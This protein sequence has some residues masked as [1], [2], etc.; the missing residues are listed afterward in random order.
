MPIFDT[1]SPISVTIELGVG[2][3]DIAASDRTDTMVEVRP[4]DPSDESDVKTARQI[5]VEYTGG[6]L[7]ITG[8]KVGPFDFSRKTRS[9][10]VSVEL[11]AGSRLQAHTQV[12]DLSVT[13]RLGECRFKSGTGHVQLEDC[14]PLHLNT[15]AGHVTIGSVAGDADVSTGTGKVRIGRID[16]NAVIK[17]S[18]GVT[19]VAT[20]AGE[21]KIRSANGDIVIGHAGAGVDAKTSHGGIQVREAEGGSLNLKTALGDIEI[22]I[23]EGVA[24]WLDLSTGHGRMDNKLDQVSAEPG[25]SEQ[26]VEVHAQTSFGDLTV[27]RA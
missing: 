5:R 22:G 23:A 11:P 6:E 25:P 7:L 15:G 9:V 8:P 17:T 2:R 10:V 27:R 14:G 3:V 13:G 26:T 1:P 19:D 4:A 12:G 20:V 21:A 16:G 18:G 24:A